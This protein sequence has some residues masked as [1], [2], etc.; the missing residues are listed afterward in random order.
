MRTN[1]GLHIKV[2]IRHETHEPNHK[3]VFIFSVLNKHNITTMNA[4]LL[5]V[6]S[7]SS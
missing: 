2:I 6:T 4:P 1:E 3:V 5:I 7:G